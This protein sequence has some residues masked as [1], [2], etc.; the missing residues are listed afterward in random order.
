[1]HEHIAPKK[2]NVLSYLNM[3]NANLCVDTYK[4]LHIFIHIYI[5]TCVYTFLYVYTCVHKNIYIHTY[6]HTHTH[7]YIYINVGSQKSLQY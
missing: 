4:C 6:T 5:Y 1:M 3:Y 7:T 2:P